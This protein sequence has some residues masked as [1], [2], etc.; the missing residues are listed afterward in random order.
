[1]YS[2]PLQHLKMPNLQWSK[3]T[4]IKWQTNAKPTCF[5]SW[6]RQQ[7]GEA[8]SGVAVLLAK[9][10][11]ATPHLSLHGSSCPV[12]LSYVYRY[13]GGSVHQDLLSTW[14][15]A[16][17]SPHPLVFLGSHLWNNV[18]KNARFHNSLN[19]TRQN[20]SETVYRVAKKPL[21]SPSPL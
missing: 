14:P 13:N 11:H 19:T 4:N 6:Y 20:N 10:S 2:E 16:T 15:A 12:L 7:G 21:W 5:F 3:I 9:H 8:V 18:N 1:V 17:Q